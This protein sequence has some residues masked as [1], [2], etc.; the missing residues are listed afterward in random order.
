MTSVKGVHEGPL[1]R[2]GLGSSD[3]NRST[4]LGTLSRACS[5]YTCTILVKEWKL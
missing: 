4:I 2:G 5:G 3:W 1:Q